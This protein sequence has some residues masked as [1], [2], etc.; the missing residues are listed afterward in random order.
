MSV[1]KIF[2][3]VQFTK[4]LLNKIGIVY[5]YEKWLQY[6]TT[7]IIIL[8]TKITHIAGFKTYLR[9]KGSLLLP[10]CKFCAFTYPKES[11]I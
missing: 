5:N 8:V 10:P 3:F 6:C 4:S 7:Y 9:L 1:L 2:C 11:F